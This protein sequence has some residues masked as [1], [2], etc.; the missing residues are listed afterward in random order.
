[1]EDLQKKQTGEI[2]ELERQKV[3]IVVLSETKNGQ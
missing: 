3:N 1:M 2:S